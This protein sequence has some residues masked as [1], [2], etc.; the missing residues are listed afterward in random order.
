MLHRS[1]VILFYGQER[2][3][4]RSGATWRFCDEARGQKRLRDRSVQDLK[5][6]SYGRR[7]IFK[8]PLQCA[9]AARL[10]ALRAVRSLLTMLRHQALGRCPKPRKGA[11]PLDPLPLRRVFFDNL[12]GA[13]HTQIQ[14][15][16][17]S[18]PN[19][20]RGAAVCRPGAYGQPFRI[21]RKAAKG[22]KQAMLPELR[23]TCKN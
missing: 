20:A 15:F 5:I 4:R 23:Q 6:A 9:T 3:R 2:K 18:R 7:Q 14:F 12:V 22:R 19:P 16:A 21:M 1:R 17:V 10:I 8:E 13:W 11:L